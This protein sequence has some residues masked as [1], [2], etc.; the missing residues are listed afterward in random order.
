VCT[1][2]PLGTNEMNSVDTSWMNAA[3]NSEINALNADKV[4]F[5]HFF[6]S[7]PIHLA[8][9]TWCSYWIEYPWI[10]FYCSWHQDSSTTLGFL[11]T[12]LPWFPTTLL[13][14]LQWF[15]ITSLSLLKRYNMESSS[16]ICLTTNIQKSIHNHYCK[17]WF[18]QLSIMA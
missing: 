17:I 4:N 3:G 7:L 8:Y 9:L 10:Y 1:Y 11:L 13:C 16:P 14:S 12:F 6:G 5:F 15:Q 18:I 2:M